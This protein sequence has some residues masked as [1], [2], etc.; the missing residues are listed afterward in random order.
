M[1]KQGTAEKY[2]RPE[3]IQQVERLDLRA[4][5]IVQGFLSGLHRSP[6]KGFSTEFSEHRRYSHGDDPKDIDWRVYARTDRFFVKRFQA[7]TNLRCYLVLDASESMA[8]T[9]RQKFTKLDYAICL[10]A[11][12]GYLMIHQQDAVGLITFD[13][14]PTGFLPAKSKRAH[15]SNILGMLA[16]A[17]RRRRTNLPLALH[18]VAELIPKRSL[19]IVFSDLLAEQSAVIESLHHI[20]YRGHDV[21]IFQV[22]DEAEAGFP[23]RRLTRFVDPETG[24]YLD[25]DARAVRDSY[26][27]EIETFVDYY[28]RRCYEAHIDFVQVDTSMGFDHALLSYLANRKARF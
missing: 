6:Y 19:V 4:R 1:A 20:R 7:E 5:F 22:L 3:V 10:A 28:R 26:L 8:Y 13:E 16:R 21:I 2:L 17:H 27:G 9:Y 24:E 18:S 25:V 14:E 23:F 11:S 15:L 12:L